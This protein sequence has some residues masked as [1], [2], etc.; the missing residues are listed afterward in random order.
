MVINSNKIKY[1]G[2]TVEAK[3]N[4]QCLKFTFFEIFPG[5]FVFKSHPCQNS[6][7][8]TKLVHKVK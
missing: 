3:G 7:V 8:T 5:E 2:N 1:C 6:A 4:D